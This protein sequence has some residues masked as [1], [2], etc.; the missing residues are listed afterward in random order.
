M[1]VYEIQ[2]IRPL[3]LTPIMSKQQFSGDVE[4]RVREVKKHH[5]D[6][7]FKIEKMNAKYVKK[8]TGTKCL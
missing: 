2:P 6:A 8:A 3:D 1:V 7:R 5:E 4:V